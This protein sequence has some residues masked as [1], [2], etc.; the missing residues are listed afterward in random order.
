MRSTN[1]K[2]RKIEN[3]MEILR[4]ERVEYQLLHLINHY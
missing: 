1:Q 3:K 2:K 4:H